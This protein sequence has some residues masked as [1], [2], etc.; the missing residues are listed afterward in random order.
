VHRVAFRAGVRPPF[1]AGSVFGFLGR[2]AVP[3]VET[4]DGR[5]YRRSLQLPGGPAVLAVHLPIGMPATVTEVEAE[6]LLTDAG[7]VGAAVGTVRRLFDLDADPVAVDATLATDPLLGPAVSAR[8]GLRVPGAVDPVELLVRAVLGQQVSVAGARTVAG[9]LAAAF[10]S[11][12]GDLGDHGRPGALGDPG[13]AGPV[14]V[15]RLFPTAA[16]FA[17]VDPGT[18]PLPG[19]RAR[20]LVGACRAVADGRVVLDAPVAELR[21][22]LLALPGIGPWTADYVLMRACAATDVFLAG[23]LGIR[24]ALER[25]GADGRPGPAAQR[26]RAWAPWRSYATLHLWATLDG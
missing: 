9:R 8:P 1:D 10:G 6:A 24:R 3:G 4:W 16:R 26:A 25:L 22:A 2:R 23:D 14:G 21:P 11:P 12:L 20:A 15:L 19:A 5:T 18:L 13:G 7:D 17:E